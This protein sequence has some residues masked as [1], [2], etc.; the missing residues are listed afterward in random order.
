MGSAAHFLTT[1][2]VRLARMTFFL[3]V[4]LII[5]NGMKAENP[6][7]QHISSYAFAAAMPCV[8]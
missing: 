6:L 1:E 3:F 8:G 2:P 4:L 5:D 7:L